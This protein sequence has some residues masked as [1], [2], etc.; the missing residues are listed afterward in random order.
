[1]FIDLFLIGV[2]ASPFIVLILYVMY[3]YKKTLNVYG[4]K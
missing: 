4:V 3:A 2:I 1:M